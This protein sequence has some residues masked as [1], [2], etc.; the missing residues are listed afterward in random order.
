MFKA[1]GVC[2]KCKRLFWLLWECD[3]DDLEALDFGNEYNLL[4]CIECSS[5]EDKN[6]I[7]YFQEDK[8]YV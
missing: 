2:G 1:I 6:F 5:K 7:K 4:E 8:K 3:S